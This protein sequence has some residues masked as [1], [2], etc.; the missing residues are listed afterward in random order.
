MSGLGRFDEEL[1]GAKSILYEGVPAKVLPIE[2]VLAS[3]RAANRKKDQA[4]IPAL[5][6]ALAAIDGDKPKG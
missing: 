1:A 3:K 4:S 5:E 6:E 2:R